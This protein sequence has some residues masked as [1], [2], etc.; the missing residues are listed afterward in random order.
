M[1]R[2]V[3]KKGS[4][5]TLSQLILWVFI[6]AL[7]VVSNYYYQPLY[8]PL[9][10]SD[11]AIWVLM[12]REFHWPDGLY[13]WG[14]NR[15]GSFIPLLAHLL[16]TLG[17]SALFSISILQLLVQLS[18]LGLYHKLAASS[19]GVLFLALIIFFPAFP[20]HSIIFP[21]HPYLGQILG[22]L[23]F[24]YILEGLRNHP[25]R[26]LWG[27]FLAVVMLWISETS[28]LVIFFA[29]IFYRKE[30]FNTGWKN[31][32]SGTLILLVGMILILIARNN[33]PTSWGYD[34]FFGSLPE[35]YS[36]L[37]SMVSKTFGYFTRQGPVVLIAF[38]LLLGGLFI[39]VKNQNQLQKSLSMSGFSILAV[40]LI[41][42]WVFLNGSGSRYF[43]FPWYLLLISVAFGFGKARPWQRITLILAAGIIGWDGVNPIKPGFRV[44][45]SRPTRE[46]IETIAGE[47]IPF[48]AVGD[49]WSIYAY[50]ALRP[51]IK[52]CSINEYDSR[53]R[54]DREQVLDS[55]TILAINTGISDSLTLDQGKR[56]YLAIAPP[57]KVGQSSYRIYKSTESANNRY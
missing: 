44:S 54:W 12:T 21:S 41:S 36:N 38:A 55:D 1:N 35:A 10:N 56:L 5:T 40:T 20:F 23:A 52:V 19:S 37:E 9:F 45:P 49:Y 47:N 33:L 14:Q 29:L 26:I 16:Y 46:E 48:N 6:L 30:V 34:Q 15:L 11:H 25:R 51:G 18:I 53:N 13:F 22:I 28:L 42:H 17:F 2:Q 8:S 7:A 32:F 3:F 39:H 43:G 4:H 57:V 31:I 24:L 27:G 50:G